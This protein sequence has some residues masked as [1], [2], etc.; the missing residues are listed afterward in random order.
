M[1]RLELGGANKWLL[2]VAAKQDKNEQRDGVFPHEKK[3]KEIPFPL[4]I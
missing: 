3:F 4:Y 2:E 1:V